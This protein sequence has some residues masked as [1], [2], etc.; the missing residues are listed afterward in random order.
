[1]KLYWRYKRPDG[2]WTYR[3][4]QTVQVPSKYEGYQIV[5]DWE[6]EE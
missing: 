1:M 3:R 6:E 5:V 4:A 2:K